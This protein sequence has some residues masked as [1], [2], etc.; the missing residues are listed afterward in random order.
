[1][2]R[3]AIKTASSNNFYRHCM[4]SWFISSLNRTPD[5]NFLYISNWD[6]TQFASKHASR[7]KVVFI[8][9]DDSFRSI[10]NHFVGWRLNLVDGFCFLIFNVFRLWR[11]SCLFFCHCGVNRHHTFVQQIRVKKEGDE[12][13][14][15]RAWPKIEL[16]YNVVT[17][18]TSKIQSKTLPHKTN[19]IKI[20]IA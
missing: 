14:F 7:K 3:R 20:R 10:G 18:K 6:I 4:F 9:S 17:R 13:N 2:S 16:Y 5:L 8:A 11:P 1:M 15:Q 12:I 19:I